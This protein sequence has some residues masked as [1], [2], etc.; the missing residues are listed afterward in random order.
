[1]KKIL[2]VLALSWWVAWGYGSDQHIVAGP[3]SEMNKCQDA[4]DE[5]NITHPGRYDHYHCISK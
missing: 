2:A 5:L 3:F 1:M 4:A